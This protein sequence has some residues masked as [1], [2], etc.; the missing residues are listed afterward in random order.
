MPIDFSSLFHRSSKD[1]SGGG[2]VRIP[3]DRR[4][5]P[6]EWRTTHYKSYGSLPVLELPKPER[7]APFFALLQDRKSGRNFSGTGM[8][9][10]T[11]SA[12]LAH[13]C[14]ELPNGIETGQTRRV[15]PTGGVRFPIEA[16]PLVFLP[17]E[18][19]PAG[20]YHY[21]IE[22]HGLDVLHERSF[23]AADIAPLFA[24]AYGWIQDAAMALILT[25]VFQRTKHK[26]GERGYRYILLEAGHIGQNVYL[27]SQSLG[28]NCCAMGGTRDE[29]IE[30]LLDI[31]GVTESLVYALIVGP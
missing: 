8:S 31:D 17:G 19:L 2:V 14:G 1:A 21:N 23:A 12:L 7:D 29:E 10:Q 13:S 5:W 30:K 27:S 28:L 15:H 9:L 18:G 6:D 26:Y 22:R 25:A 20:I 11:L 24:S 16:Y 4:E 3:H